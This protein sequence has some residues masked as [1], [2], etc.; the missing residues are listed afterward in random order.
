MVRRMMSRITRKR[1]GAS[2]NKNIQQI[3]DAFKLYSMKFLIWL[4]AAANLVIIVSMVFQTLNVSG[5][6]KIVPPKNVE[7]RKA[8]SAL[9]VEILN[10]CGVN[11]LA[12][13]LREYLIDKNYDVVDFRDYER[14]D[15]PVTYVIDRN[16]ME[17]RNA[18]KV[19]NIMG[20]PEEHVIPQISPQR[21]LDVTVI[22]GQDYKNLKVFK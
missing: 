8:K 4:L 12:S 20:V 13:R 17:S 5:G 11:R 18:R 19:A 3:S 21:K 1:P 15:I 7:E 6:D 16:H 10:G 14:F 2:K 9:K 22:I